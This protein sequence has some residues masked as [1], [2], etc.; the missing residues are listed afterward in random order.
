MTKEKKLKQSKKPFRNYSRNTFDIEELPYI[1]M[2]ADKYG[3]GHIGHHKYIDA[4]GDLVDWLTPFN[5]NTFL[6]DELLK[7]GEVNV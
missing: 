5:T 7:R 1:M 3:D 6:R 2:L 4:K